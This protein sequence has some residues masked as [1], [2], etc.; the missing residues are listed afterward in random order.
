ML[1]ADFQSKTE[2]VTAGFHISTFLKMILQNLSQLP[3]T[4]YQNKVIREMTYVC[5]INVFP[6]HE[7][8]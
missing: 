3:Y 7:P 1:Q 8:A 2:V 4:A 6:F 5:N